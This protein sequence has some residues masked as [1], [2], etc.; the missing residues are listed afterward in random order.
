MKTV[1]CTTTRI[2]PVP[3]PKS[4]ADLRGANGTRTDDR[5]AGS[6]RSRSSPAPPVDQIHSACPLLR[7]PSRSAPPALD[8]WPASLAARSPCGLHHRQQS[9]HMFRIKSSP[10]HQAPAILQPNFDPRVARYVGRRLRHLNF[11]ESRRC[12]FPQPFLPP[13]EMRRAQLPL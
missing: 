3:K 13:V 7:W 9:P 10:Y 12:V 2:H 1:G 8:L 4:S 6:L 11:H 5:S